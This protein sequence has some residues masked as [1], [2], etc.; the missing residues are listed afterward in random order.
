MPVHPRADIEGLRVGGNIGWCTSRDRA[1]MYSLV[2][3]EM[4]RLAEGL[5]A[6]RAPEWSFPRVHTF[7][8]AEMAH[9]AEGLVAV[10]APNE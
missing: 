5:V 9:L 8:G 4:P 3:S 6:M 2:P 1:T 10:R 7:V